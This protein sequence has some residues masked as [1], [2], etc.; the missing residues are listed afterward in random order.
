MVALFFIIFYAHSSHAFEILA[1]SSD[2]LGNILLEISYTGGCSEQGHE[3]HITQCHR[4]SEQLYCQANLLQIGPRDFC[5]AMVQESLIIRPSEIF[6]DVKLR[7]HLQN[8]SFLLEITPVQNQYHDSVA[9]PQLETLPLIL[10][11]SLKSPKSA[12]IDEQCAL[13]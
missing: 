11:P 8:S 3:L 6:I 9:S 7:R 10:I 12:N 1:A 5:K 4:A 2:K 13:D